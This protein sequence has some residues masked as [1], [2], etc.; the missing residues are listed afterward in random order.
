MKNFDWER[1][2]NYEIVVN[3]KTEKSAI[4][5]FKELLNHGIYKWCDETDIEI[6]DNE[7]NGVN[8]AYCYDKKSFFV[9]ETWRQEGK[10]IVVWEYVPE[11]SLAEVINTISDETIGTK[12]ES[13]DITIQKD[14]NNTII[15]KD[16]ETWKHLKLSTEESYTKTKVYTPV[17]FEEALKEYEKGRVIKSLSTNREFVDYDPLENFEAREIRGKWIVLEIF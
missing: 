10:E 14:T 7:W 15:I 11:Y 9:S 3:C 12:Y 2:K 4:D 17:S 1:F 13:K 6:E 16:K 8:T 5:F